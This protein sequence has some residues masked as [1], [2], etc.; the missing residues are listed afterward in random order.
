MMLCATFLGHIFTYCFEFSEQD[1]LREEIRSLEMVR[2]KM[3]ERIKEL[4]TEVRDLKDK[5]E[6]R[7]EDD[8]V[9]KACIK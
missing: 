1:I 5:L 2:T 7:G 3:N 4:E 9:G 8:Q 6:V